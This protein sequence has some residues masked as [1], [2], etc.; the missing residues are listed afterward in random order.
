MADRHYGLQLGFVKDRN[1]PEKLGRITAHVPGVIEETDWALPLG[2]VGGGSKQRGFWMVPAI[3]ASVGIMF[4]NGDPQAAPWFL[5]GNWGRGETPTGSDVDVVALETE[6]WL[7]TLDDR[8]GTSGKAE[9]RSKTTGDRWLIDHESHKVALVAAVE[10]DLGATTASHPLVLGDVF[11][12]L[13]NTLTV[14]S[15][16]GPLGPPLVQMGAAQLSA[17]VKTE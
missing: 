17:K 14:P 3:G 9:L 5:S 2:A 6:H 7:L 4:E 13:Y 15:P 11:Q 16:F 1:D 8:E 10:V 12:L